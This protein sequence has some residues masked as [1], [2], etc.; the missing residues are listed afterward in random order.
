MVITDASGAAKLSAIVPKPPSLEEIISVDGP[1]GSILGFFDLIGRAG[2]AFEPVATGKDDPALM[3][4]TSGTT[5]LPKGALHAHRVLP[6]HLPGVRFSHDFLPQPGDLM[7]TPADWAW[8][9]GLLNAVLPCLHFGVPVVAQRR[10]H[11][12]PDTVLA[13][14][15]DLQIRNA[16]IPPTAL[17]MLRA[18]HGAPVSGLALRSL[19]SA[20]EALGTET[21]EWARQALGVEPNDVY[22][23]TEC[24]YVLGSSAMLGIRKPG[25]IGRAVPGHTVAVIHPDGTICEPG[26]PGEIAVA[27]PDPAMFLGYWNQPEATAAKF[28]GAWMTTG[29]Q[30]VCDHEGYV[31]FIG[32]SDDIITSSGF[33]IGPTE[34]EECLLRHPAVGGAAAVGK[35]DPIRTEIV[36]AYVVLR[37]GFGASAEL[38]DD[39]KAFVRTRLSAHEYPREVDFVPELPMTATGKIMRRV[40]RERG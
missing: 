17:R 11:F 14:L 21:R 24:N 26:E 29:D 36:K 37:E 7:W 33:R 40:L 30:A 28:A 34:I 38:A 22:G 18:Q 10:D 9:G 35:P 6:G 13:L 2:G 12:D 19:S 31:S 8:A 15:R 25:A 23:Q 32:R 3:I 5:G 1:D 4:Y 16:F 20:G 39:I 27:R